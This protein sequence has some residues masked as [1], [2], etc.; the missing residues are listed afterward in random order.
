GRRRQKAVGRRQSPRQEPDGFCFLPSAFYLLPSSDCRLPTADCRLRVNG[1]P[2]LVMPAV[3]TH[4]VGQLRLLAVRALREGR[5]RQRVVGAPLVAAGLAVAV[6]WVGHR[7]P[8]LSASE[9]FRV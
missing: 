9:L 8:T 2:A 6:L 1:L 7:G 4:A 5:G 3:R